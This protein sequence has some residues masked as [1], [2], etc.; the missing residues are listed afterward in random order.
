[1]PSNTDL[2]N[3]LIAVRE[4]VAIHAS[5]HERLH[6]DT[7]TSKQVENTIK[8]CEVTPALHERIDTLLQF[9]RIVAETYGKA[10]GRTQLNVCALCGKALNMID[11]EWY[12]NKAVHA[13]WIVCESCNPK[14]NK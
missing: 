4:Y 11:G 8:W 10:L 12:E 3:A 14:S 13:W 7:I 2:Q 1:M 5:E 6:P 9:M